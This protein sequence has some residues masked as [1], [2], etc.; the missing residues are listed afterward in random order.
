LIV[1]SNQIMPFP[2]LKF[3]FIHVA[4]VTLCNY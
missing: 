2:A 1:K 3:M 4:A